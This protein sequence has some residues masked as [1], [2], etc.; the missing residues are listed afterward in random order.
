[1]PRYGLSKGSSENTDLMMARATQI[2]RTLRASGLTDDECMVSLAMG[3][4]AIKAEAKE[5]PDKHN[6]IDLMALIWDGWKV[7][8]IDPDWPPGKSK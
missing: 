5:P 6:M 7:A 4:A 8:M 2:V 3:M 1:M